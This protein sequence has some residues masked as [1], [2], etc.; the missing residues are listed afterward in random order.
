MSCIEY[1][2]VRVLFPAALSWYCEGIA[3]LGSAGIPAGMHRRC[4]VNYEFWM[5]NAE[6]AMWLSV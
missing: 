6:Y 1:A 3:E 5:G 4:N 2:P